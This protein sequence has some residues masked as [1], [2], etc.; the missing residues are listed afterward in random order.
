[1]FIESFETNLSQLH[2]Q[3]KV[4]L[5]QLIDSTG[6]PADWVAAGDKRTYAD[7][8]KPAGL[9][10]VASTR[11]RSARTDADHP[12]RPG[13]QPWSGNLPGQRRAQVG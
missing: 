2:D 6:A 7:M 5:V 12:D 8:I 13:G 1:V 9:A 4:P 3:L 10:E 11:R